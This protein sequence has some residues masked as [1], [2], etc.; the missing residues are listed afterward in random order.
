M[1]LAVATAAA[2]LGARARGSGLLV[3]LAVATAV[4]L[5]GSSASAAVQAPASS[6]A[7]CAQALPEW[8][9]CDD[10]ESDRLGR[11]FER[12]TAQGRFTREEGAGLQGSTG[13]VAHWDR[14]GQVSAGHLH[15]AFGPTPD[16]YFRPVDDGTERRREIYWRLYLRLDPEWSGGSGYKLSR[17]TSFATPRWAQAMVAHVWGGRGTTLAIDPTSG[18][19]DRGE[20]RTTTYNDFANFRWLGATGSNTAVFD[21]RRRGRWQCIEAQVA[22]EGPGQRDGVFRLWIDGTLEAERV[23]LDWVGGSGDYG[24]NALFIE[25]YWDGGAPGPN[26]RFLDNLVVSTRPIGCLP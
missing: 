2:M 25:N 1:P 17:A 11:Y 4:G 15:L 14:I 8:I 7:E 10:F 5:L 6:P 16:P 9:W 26:R 12:S 3:T 23:G 24:I 20:L 18:T 13:M 21:E 19:S 22:L